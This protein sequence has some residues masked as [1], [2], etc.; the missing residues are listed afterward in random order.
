MWISEVPRRE[1]EAIRG[2]TQVDDDGAGEGHLRA[3]G[4]HEVYSAEE[5]KKL[6][7]A[8]KPGLE[9]ALHMTA[10]LTG[11]RHGE[12]DG[13]QWDRVDFEKSRIFVARSLTQ[14]KGG[15]IIEKP[16]TRAAYRYLPMTP[17][18]VSELK[19][20]KLQSPVN[21]HDLVFAD[22]LGRALNRKS[23][24]RRLKQAAKRAKI[25][26][27]SMHNLRH[28]F[29]SQHFMAGTVPTEISQLMGHSNVG[30][31]QEVYSAI[32]RTRI[33]R[34]RR[35]RWN[36]ATSRAEQAVNEVSKMSL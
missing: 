27:L 34:A 28:T 24:N 8:S 4:P 25:K 3:V 15:A 32:G 16:K 17:M 2:L 1:A 33:I 22:P 7:D 30:V 29:A 23:N 21:E 5:V 26:A 13:L 20:W 35:R 14:L 6:I 36:R 18:L 11:M 12:L 9:K 10:V 31:T 19:R